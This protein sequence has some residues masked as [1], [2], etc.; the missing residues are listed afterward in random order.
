MYRRLL[1]GLVGGEDAAMVVPGV[2]KPLGRR[3]RQK[4]R[5]ARHSKGIVACTPF[6]PLQPDMCVCAV[7]VHRTPE[8]RRTKPRRPEL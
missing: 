4:T 7:G 6:L 3:R 8:I 2:K 1:Q 5:Q